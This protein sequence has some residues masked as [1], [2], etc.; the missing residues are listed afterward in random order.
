MMM[1]LC[2]TTYSRSQEEVKQSNVYFLDLRPPK[3]S[4]NA[5]IYNNKNS[6]SLHNSYIGQAI[7]NKVNSSRSR[8]KR[9]SIQTPQNH[10]FIKKGLKKGSLKDFKDVK[11]FKDFQENLNLNLTSIQKS[12]NSKNLSINLQKLIS[13]R[14]N[15]VK[16][17]SRANSRYYKDFSKSKIETKPS[18]ENVKNS[19][20]SKIGGASSIN[21]SKIKKRL[22][23]R[24]HSMEIKSSRLSVYLKNYK[25]LIFQN[26]KFLGNFKKSKKNRP[27][28][29]SSQTGSLSR[30]NNS[31]I[32]NYSSHR[33]HSKEKK[34][35]KQPINL[36]SYTVRTRRGKNDYIDKT[37]QDSF[38][39]LP[40]FNQKADTHIF[41]VYDGHG[42]LLHL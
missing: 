35:K 21:Y 30:L 18:F 15:S 27:L 6:T 20:N 11:E 26:S 1:M 36:H 10:N 5:H 22:H 17:P 31:N 9:S 39:A 3:S 24:S 16:T 41:G 42:I 19:K 28:Y 25:K 38:V 12:R 2:S 34:I 13:H 7:K 33:Q 4:K 32:N 37:N 8:G 40:N 23:K 14:K 29:S